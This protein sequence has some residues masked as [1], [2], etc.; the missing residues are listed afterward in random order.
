MLL[1]YFNKINILITIFVVSLFV[2]LMS[3]G[4]SNSFFKDINITFFAQRIINKCTAES[5]HPACYDREIPKLMQKG[6][7]T[8]E[9]TFEVTKK[10]QG[11]DRTYLYCHVL[12]HELA[13]IETR[14]DPEKWLDVIARCPTLTCNNGCEHG[15]VMRRFKGSDVLSESQLASIIPDLKIAC[16]PRGDWH[17]TEV[18]RSMCYHSLGHL[19]M[20]ITDANLEKSLNI[21]KEVGIKPDGRNYYQ[22]CVQGAFMIIFQPLDQDDISLVA[23][24]KPKK[25]DVIGFCSKY[26]GSLNIACRTEAWPY[27]FNDFKNPSGLINFCKFTKNEYDRNW[28]YDTGLR[29]HL[30]L[31]ILQSS[32][33]VGVISYCLALPVN[34]QERCVASIANGWVQDE[35]NYITD[36]I[37]LC[38]AAEPYRFSDSCYKGLLFFSKFSF[39]KGSAGWI[40][41]CNNFEGKYRD[42]CFSGRVPDGW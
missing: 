35:P 41:Y 2:F 39:N 27:Y 15:A 36:S 22:T 8:M 38:K 13:D 12:G 30:S 14:K 34:M 3:K 5:Y 29:G 37:K 16:E 26:I 1:K 40:S 9:E 42:E 20:Y 7:L 18:E 24:I 6:F 28:C 11:S 31:D 17:P 19:A 23:K 33:V 4:A 21:C 10:I 32:G 25:E